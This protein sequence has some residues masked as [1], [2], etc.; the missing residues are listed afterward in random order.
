MATPW[1]IERF[2]TPDIQVRWDTK[3][4]CYVVKS[5]TEV[6]TILERKRNGIRSSVGFLIPKDGIDNYLNHMPAGVCVEI[7][8]NE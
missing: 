3:W 7:I 5:F 4:K 1:Q 6:G 8:D 2:F